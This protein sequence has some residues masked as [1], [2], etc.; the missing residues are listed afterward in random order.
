MWG[1]LKSLAGSVATAKPQE[2]RSPRW[3][4]VRDAWLKAHPECACCGTR[5]HLTVHHIWPFSWPGG[6]ELEL[7]FRNFITLCET[8]GH[9]CHH[10]IA[11]LLDWRSCNPT[12]QADAA[13]FR[14]R[15]AERPYPPK[16]AT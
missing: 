11:H 12:V 10:A 1:W 16:D 13:W 9:N 7:D 5:E 6:H 15:I 4:K 3:P 2:P 14:R 8:P